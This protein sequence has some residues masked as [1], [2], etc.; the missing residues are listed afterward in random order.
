MAAKEWTGNK[1]FRFRID[2]LWTRLG[3]NYFL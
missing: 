2:L 1:M 3:G